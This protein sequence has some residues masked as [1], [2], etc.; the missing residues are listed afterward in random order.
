MI[1]MTKMLRLLLHKANV[2]IKVAGIRGQINIGRTSLSY[3]SVITANSNRYE[4]I[5]SRKH[6]TMNIDR[7]CRSE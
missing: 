2:K 5:Y 3:K 6:V 4:N 7:R 1:S